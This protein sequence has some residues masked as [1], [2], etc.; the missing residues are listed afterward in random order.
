MEDLDFR[1]RRCIW[2][3]P[4]GVDPVRVTFGGVPTG[5]RLVFHAGLYYRDERMEEHGPV[6]VRVLVDGE[7][8]G[9]LLHRDGDGWLRLEL[10]MPDAEGDTVTVTVETTADK[11]ARR[12]LCWSGTV[13]GTPA[14]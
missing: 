7:P 6:L 8:V 10:D 9:Q 14:P 12:S 5:D 4:A 3:H 13:Q 11:P 2:Q 1:P